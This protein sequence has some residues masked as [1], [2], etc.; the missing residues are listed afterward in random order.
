MNLYYLFGIVG[1]IVYKNPIY[2]NI[3][4]TAI[5]TVYTIAVQ[6]M[7]YK[8]IKKINRNIYEVGVYIENKPYNVRV[9]I[10][11]GPS[12]LEDVLYENKSVLKDIEPYLNVQNI[13]FVSVTPGE[14]GYTKP[15]TFDYGGDIQEIKPTESLYKLKNQ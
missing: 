15:L 1:F 14:L 12:L 5:K 13:E 10:Q 8:N 6:S 4:Q 2:Y 3:I 7:I 11:R 9:K